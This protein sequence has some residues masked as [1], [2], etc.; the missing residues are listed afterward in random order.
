MSTISSDVPQRLET[1]IRDR[2]VGA[3][4]DSTGL[5]SALLQTFGEASR[6]AAH[7]IS[8]LR[9][10]IPQALAAG[11]LDGDALL[12]KMHG[13]NADEASKSAI[14][15]WAFALGVKPTFAGPAEPSPTMVHLVPPADVPLPHVEVVV[16]NTAP[17]APPQVPVASYSPPPRKS[18][19][20]KLVVASL[21]IGLLGI[22]GLGYYFWK[23]AHDMTTPTRSPNVPLASVTAPSKSPNPAEEEVSLAG[24]TAGNGG[25]PKNTKPAAVKSPTKPAVTAPAP[26]QADTDMAAYNARLAEVRREFTAANT[27]FGRQNAALGNEE[28]TDTALDSAAPIWDTWSQTL[29][30]IAGELDGITPPPSAGQVHRKIA[31]NIRQLAGLASQASQAARNHDETQFQDYSGQI[32]SL[33]NSAGQELNSLVV[34]AGFDPDQF[35]RDGTLVKKK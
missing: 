28:D 19:N 8:T 18:S 17:V 16:P 33:A 13:G 1:L 27:A 6:D 32:G 23:Q 35:A 11:N 30:G 24:L 14:R 26:T 7:L 15:A 21:L 31:D 12:L 25:L 34:A 4:S 5:E 29:L 10:G 2:G 22:S 9:A 20:G 3:L